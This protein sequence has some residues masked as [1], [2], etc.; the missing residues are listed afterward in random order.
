[1]IRLTVISVGS[2]KESYLSAAVAEYEKR[3]SAFCRIENVELKE[4][5]IRNE[6]DEAEIAAA[7][8]DEGTRILARIPEGA[9]TFALCVEGRAY[10]SIELSRLLGGAAD[11]SGKLC[12]IIGSSHGL[13]AR[14]KAACRHRLSLSKL[15]FPHQLMRVI[16]LE[17]LYRSFMIRAGKAYH[18]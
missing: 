11:Q 3:L 15:T 6:D 16:L 12:L 14:V 10:D 13:S 2:L 4:A 9:V 5:R 17:T 8:E 18:K 7:L 1:M